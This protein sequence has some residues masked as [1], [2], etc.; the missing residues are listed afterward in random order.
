LASA[1]ALGLGMA[2]GLG[3]AVGF[4]SAGQGHTLRHTSQ[5]SGNLPS[6]SPAH[7][8]RFVPALGDWEGTANGFPASFRLSYGRDSRGNLSYGL[9]TLV[10]LRPAGCP[11]SSSRYAEDVI[12]STRVNPLGR[13]GSLGLSRFGFGGAMRAARTATLS[14]RYRLGSC[15]GTLNWHMHPATRTPVQD[16][17]WHLHYPGGESSSFR[18]Q[19]GGRLA[20]QIDVAP[21][22]KRCNGVSGQYDLFIGPNGRAGTS[23]RGLR[24]SIRFT[25]RGGSGQIDGAG[26][27]CA[28]GPFH[29]S[30]SGPEASNQP[31]R[32]PGASER[33]PGRV[34]RRPS[35]PGAGARGRGRSPRGSSG[36]GRRTPAPRIPAPN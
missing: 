5:A 34:S 35:P 3:G 28:K 12:S 7:G 29:F 15:S 36:S 22:L 24:A 6:I 19:A 32:G 11:V 23:Q 33:R 17:L 14:T 9:D 2:L 16:G 31:R 20:S 8:K 13:A 4:A 26:S 1:A 30:V 10:A 27:G 18:V 25:R 21:A